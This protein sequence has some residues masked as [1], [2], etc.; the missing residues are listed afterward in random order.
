M[1]AKIAAITGLVLLAI[2]AMLSLATVIC[3]C[4][5]GGKAGEI[6]DRLSDIPGGDDHGRY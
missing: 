5:V 2:I 3:T 1:I 6:L 4:Y